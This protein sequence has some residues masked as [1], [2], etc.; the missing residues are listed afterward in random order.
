LQRG[1]SPSCFDRV[2]ASRLGVAAGEALRPGHND[3]MAGVIDDKIE[4][5]PFGI[6]ISTKSKINEDEVRIARIL[7]I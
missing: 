1:G 2:L 4:L 6:A 7:S 3:V 5:T